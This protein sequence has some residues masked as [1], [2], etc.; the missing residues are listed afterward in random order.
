MFFKELFSKR[1]LIGNGL[2]LLLIIILIIWAEVSPEG[3]AKSSVEDGPIENLTAVFLG[4]SCI[5]FIVVLKKSQFLKQHPGWWRYFF[6]IGWILLMFIFAG[7]EISWGQRI[8]GFDTPEGIKEVN[9]QDEFNVHN[10][11]FIVVT[12]YRLLSIFMFLTGCLF[13]F[14][15][16]FD[17]G[18][19]LFQKLAFPVLPLSYSSLFI[20]SYIYGKY[21]YYLPIDAGTEM[22]EM[23]MGMGMAAFGIHGLFKPDDLFLY[24]KN[25]AIP[26]DRK[27]K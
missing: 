25:K 2:I 4:L 1:T 21:Y 3:L 26:F 24:K 8:F 22:R 5:G 20:A 14:L 6:I 9:A 17:W 7:E 16:V 27:M 18:K 19:R 23:I 13:P 15:A 12:K 11:E 10:L